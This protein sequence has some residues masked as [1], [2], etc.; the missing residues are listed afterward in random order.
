MG[1]NIPEPTLMSGMGRTMWMVLESEQSRR[2]DRS[3]E[4]VF[5]GVPEKPDLI[6]RGLADF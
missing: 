5:C 1:K 4:S 3:S 2:K 6:K